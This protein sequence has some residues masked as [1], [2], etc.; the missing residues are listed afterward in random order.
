MGEVVAV[1]GDSCFK[2]ECFVG[3]FVD[4]VFGCCGEADEVGVEVSEYVF[5][6]I[7]DAAV[8]FVDDDEVEVAAGEEFSSVVIFDVVDGVHHCLI[9]REYC[10]CGCDIFV[11][12]EVDGG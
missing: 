3:I 2:A 10:P 4:F 12:T 8:C 1:S 5:V 11:L 9:G 7:V 6:F